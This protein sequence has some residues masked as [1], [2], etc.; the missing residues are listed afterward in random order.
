MR[1]RKRDRTEMIG[2]KESHG[3]TERKREHEGEREKKWK[4]EKEEESEL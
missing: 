3:K 4:C 2:D 1:E